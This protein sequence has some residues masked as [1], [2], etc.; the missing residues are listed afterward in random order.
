MGVWSSLKSP[1]CTT[2]ATGVR[3]NTPTASGIEWFTAK[4]SK[5][6]GPRVTWPPSRISCSFTFLSLCSSSL[7]LIS[8]SVSLVPS[9]GRMAGE[10]LQQV[11]QRARVVLVAVSDDDA[12]QLV[13]PLHDVAEVGEDQ[14]DPGM[15]VVGE[16]DAGVDDHHVVAVLE[17]SHVLADA[18]KPTEGDDT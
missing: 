6:N 5:P 17:H 9:T 10:R 1:V 16:H 14:V 15:V 18:V 13:L 12:A 7:P 4:K 8:P 2:F 3:T 11:R